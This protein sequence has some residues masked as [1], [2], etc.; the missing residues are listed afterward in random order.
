MAPL[1]LAGAIT[2]VSLWDKLTGYYINYID[3]DVAHDFKINYESR[4]KLF[5]KKSDE[6]EDFSL[7]QLKKSSTHFVEQGK[8]AQKYGYLSQIRNLENIIYC[9]PKEVEKCTSTLELQLLIDSVVPVVKPQNT[10]Q[11]QKDIHKTL[12]EWKLFIESGKYF[13][14]EKERLLGLPFMMFRH[15][16]YPEP[17]FG[18]WQYKLFEELFSHPYSY[19]KDEIESE[20]K[21]H[22]F[23]YKNFL[24]PSV[25]EKY[26]DGKFL[27]YYF[28]F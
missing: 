18:T 22:K 21:I 14:S 23:N 10:N 20:E 28:Y 1:F 16:Q 15:Q 2:G 19:G 26:G 11:K 7:K 25:V 4:Y 6:V 3:Y 5:E 8:N 9:D 13:D 17:H 24:H 12:Y 27:I